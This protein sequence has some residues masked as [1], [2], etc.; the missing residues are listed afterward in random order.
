M[1][2]IYSLGSPLK[3]I[4]EPVR[5]VIPQISAEVQCESLKYADAYREKSPRAGRTAD[6]MDDMTDRMKGY[7]ESY[8]QELGESIF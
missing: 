5:E 1:L 8:A 2:G 6:R 4:N 3:V 7:G